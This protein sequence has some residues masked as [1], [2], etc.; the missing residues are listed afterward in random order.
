MQDARS[1]SLNFRIIDFTLKNSKQDF[2][3]DFSVEIFVEAG[4]LT[5]LNASKKIFYSGWI[6]LVRKHTG[7]RSPFIPLFH[8]KSS[9]SRVSLVLTCG[10]WSSWK[11]GTGSLSERTKHYTLVPVD[12]HWMPI[13]SVTVARQRFKR[14]EGGRGAILTDSGLAT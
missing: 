2:S 8:S 5:T 14:I 13:G 3:S 7:F 1:M 9:E 10:H 12:S 11:T 4:C 6:P